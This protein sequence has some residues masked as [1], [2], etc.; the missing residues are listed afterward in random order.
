M[1]N[2]ALN[3]Y[4]KTKKNLILE[5]IFLFLVDIVLKGINI[6]FTKSRKIQSNND[7]IRTTNVQPMKARDKNQPSIHEQMSSRCLPHDLP[8]RLQIGVL[9]APS[10]VLVA[11]V[12]IFFLI[13]QVLV[14]VKEKV[15]ENSTSTV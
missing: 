9:V 10:L 15:H 6:Y 12:I 1:Q 14:L 7:L 5:R 3:I 11:C 8:C 13:T 4:N 2:R